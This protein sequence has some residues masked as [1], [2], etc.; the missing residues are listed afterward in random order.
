[1]DFLKNWD[2]ECEEFGLTKAQK[3]RKLPC[4]C[5]QDIREA[6][7]YLNGYINGD[8]AEF[9]RELKQLFWQTDPPKETM[10]ALFKLIGDARAGKMSVDMYVLKY[11]AITQ[12]L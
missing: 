9:Q 8:W 2:L 7:E 6:I 1:L 5:S 3:C 12:A 4:Y 10:A 11:T